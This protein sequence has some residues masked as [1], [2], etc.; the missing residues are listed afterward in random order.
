MTTVES[1]NEAIK[2]KSTYEEPQYPKLLTK[3]DILQITSTDE[4]PDPQITAQNWVIVENKTGNLLYS[5]MEHHST[6]VASLT[7]I[8][9]SYCVLNLVEQMRGPYCDIETKINILKPVSLVSGTTANL[10]H[11][12]SLSVRSLIYG[13]MLPSGNDAA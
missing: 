12:D 11:N 7:K 4:I 6:Q 10:K 9:T 3:N 5:K 8:M 2:R 1:L 13:M